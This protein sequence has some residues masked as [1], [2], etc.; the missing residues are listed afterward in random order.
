VRRGFSL[1]CP[2]YQVVALDTWGRT[3][4]FVA[5]TSCVICQALVQRCVLLETASLHGAL[6]SH[7]R[8]REWL[9]RKLM[10]VRNGVCPV[11]DNPDQVIEISSSKAT[12]NPIF[13]LP[14]TQISMN[15]IFA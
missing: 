15:K 7:F 12:E 1:S 3:A 5:Q 2:P 14:K 8:R 6:L 4:G 9:A 13:F 10:L 11:A